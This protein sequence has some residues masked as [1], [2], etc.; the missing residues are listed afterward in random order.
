MDSNMRKPLW[1]ILAI[2]IIF[3]SFQFTNAQTVKDYLKWGDRAY[4]EFKNLVALGFYKKAYDL[5]TSNY[6]VLLKISK[7]YNS[8]YDEAVEDSSKNQAKEFAEQALDIST[9][10][11]DLFPDSSDSYA[12][13]AIS[14]G[15]LANI[16]GSK[17][18]I[19]L[20]KKVADNAKEAIQKNPDSFLPYL[21]MGIYY[22]EIADLNWFE[23]TFANLFYGKVPEGSVDESIEMLDKAYK[24]NPKVIA[25][26]YHLAL[27]YKETGNKEKEIF[28]LKRVIELPRSDFKDKFYK[29][30]A[31]T[32]LGEVD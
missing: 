21:V 20:S 6:T 17:E 24:I 8:L 11:S 7:T 22:K 26:N 31:K 2:L 29:E 9:K 14:Y 19:R 23:R 27:D 4:K 18:K 3:N 1:I 28:Y 13:M 25:T 12:Y 16:S 10:M 32:R 30:K 15:N 5:D